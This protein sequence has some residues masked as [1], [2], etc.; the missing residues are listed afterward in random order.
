MMVRGAAMPGASR[1]GSSSSSGGSRWPGARTE[2][3]RGR[4][5]VTA[6]MLLFSACLALTCDSLL[7][8]A[9]LCTLGLVGS[10]AIVL[11]KTR[12]TCLS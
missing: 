3:E 4:R 5:Y 11:R 1:G 7:C 6:A 9:L 10:L 12:R 2:P 8:A